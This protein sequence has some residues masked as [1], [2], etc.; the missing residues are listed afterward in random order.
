[1]DLKHKKHLQSSK[2]GIN[3]DL[4]PGNYGRNI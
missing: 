1:M 4:T 3:E 2:M